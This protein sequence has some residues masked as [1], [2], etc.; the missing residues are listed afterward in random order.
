MSQNEFYFIRKIKLVIKVSRFYWRSRNS[1]SRFY[2][3][4]RNSAS[5]FYWRSRNSASR[6]YWRSTG[7][8]ER[9]SIK[10]IDS[11]R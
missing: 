9:K 7:S 11:R 5:R 2:W 8:Y 10:F 3:R 6:F 4:S 1:A